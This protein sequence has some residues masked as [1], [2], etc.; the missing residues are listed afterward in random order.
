[1]LHATA[2]KTCFMW[3]HVPGCIRDGLMIVCIL[4][5]FLSFHIISYHFI[6]FHIIRHHCIS[7]YIILSHQL[8]PY[9]DQM[10]QNLMLL[11]SWHF[12]HVCVRPT[13]CYSVKINSH[14]VWNILML[15]LYNVAGINL[16]NSTHCFVALSIELP[17]YLLKYGL[18]I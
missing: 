16:V 18:I 9:F 15:I 17:H 13:L 4:D 5:D 1:M 14:Y 7:F 11:N 3:C 8:S 12:G 10:T 2:W 6:S